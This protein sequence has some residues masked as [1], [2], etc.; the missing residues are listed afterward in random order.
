V[1]SAG[2]KRAIPE[3]ERPQTHV[4]DREATGVGFEGTAYLF[5]KLV[6]TEAKEIVGTQIEG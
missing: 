2:F 4:L 3:S 5:K 1:P 6:G